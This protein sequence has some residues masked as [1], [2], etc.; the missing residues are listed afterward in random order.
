ML[1]KGKNRLNEKVTNFRKY[2]I[3]KQ[4]KIIY[5]FTTEN[6]DV[7]TKPVEYSK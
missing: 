1:D 7:T 4:G 2:G 5:V 6:F 3:S